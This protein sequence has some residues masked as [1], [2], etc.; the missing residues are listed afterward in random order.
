MIVSGPLCADAADC[1]L[2]GS[3]LFGEELRRRR[4]RRAAD[5]RRPRR[6]L[7]GR[8]ARRSATPARRRSRRCA[9]RPAA[10]CVEVELADLDAAGA[11]DGPDRQHRGPRRRHPGAAQPARPRAQFLRPTQAF[12]RGR[13]RGST[14][15]LC[16]PGAGG[17]GMERA[18]GAFPDRRRDEQADHPLPGRNP[19]SR[20]R[21][22]AGRRQSG[23]PDLEGRRR[24]LLRRAID[25]GRDLRPRRVRTDR[26]RA[27]TS[28]ATPTRPAISCS[29]AIARIAISCAR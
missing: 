19:A 22:F 29:S 5:R 4:R 25:A 11:G 8:R 27:R 7:R 16:Q 9:R 20:R 15:G 23:V 14:W 1:R 6:R 13:K 21:G 10:R 24:K 3:A 12:G 18:I 17:A 2:L 28:F 26:R